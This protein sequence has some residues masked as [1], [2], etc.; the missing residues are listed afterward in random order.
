MFGAGVANAGSFQVAPIRVNLSSSQSVIALTLRNTSNES[1][2][3]QLETMAWSQQQGKNVYVP[4]KEILATPPIFTVPA[5]GSQIVRIGLRRA[6]DA[7]REMTYALYLQEVPPP[8][9]SG[10]QGLQMALRIGI[11]VFVA[12]T[13]PSP[14]ALAWKVYRTR[15]GKIEVS[16]TNNGGIHAQVSNIR[17]A[18]VDGGELGKQQLSGYVLPNQSNS[19]QVKDVSVPSSVST[20]HLFA[21]TDGG[22]VDAGVLTVESK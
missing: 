8:P 16:L 22:E 12:P 3:V 4:T 19:W 5:G 6:P 7:Q 18:R 1:T 14:P 13:T 20:L 2:V 21:Q 10:F 11:P 9:K 15:D 17:L